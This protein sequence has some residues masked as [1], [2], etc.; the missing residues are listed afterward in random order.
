MNPLLEMLD[1]LMHDSVIRI[2]S[3]IAAKNLS[4]FKKKGAKQRPFPCIQASDI[5]DVL[6]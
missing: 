5:S 4:E 1:I 6:P 3:K 2:T